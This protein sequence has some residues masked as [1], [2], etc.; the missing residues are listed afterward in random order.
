MV[1]IGEDFV[2]PPGD[3]VRKNFTVPTNLTE[4]KWVRA[5]EILPGN[6]KLVHHVHLNSI[7]PGT[8]EDEVDEAGD[9]IQAV[10]PGQRVSRPGAQRGVF[11]QLIDGQ[12]LLRNDAPV[13]NDG[14]ASDL[15]DL[16]QL[17]TL[18]G[19]GGTSVFGVSQ[20]PGRGPEIFNVYGDGSTAKF[21][22]K[23]AKLRFAMHYANVPV[24]MSDRTKGG[25]V[26]CQESTGPAGPTHHRAES[27]LHDSGWSRELQDHS[28][29]R[30]RL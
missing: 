10:R 19:E 22:P 11:W 29:P 15:P 23:G 5:A 6:P 13:V 18:A 3:D 16:P 28:V 21:L 4:D 14:C 2:V 24:M 27:L 30:L 26:L 1:D 7:L 20:L 8:K 17:R 9:P 12:Q 25:A